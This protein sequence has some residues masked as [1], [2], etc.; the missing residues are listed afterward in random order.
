MPSVWPSYGAWQWQGAP[1]GSWAR[2]EL[3]EEAAGR[4]A[5]GQLLVKST[6][7]FFLQG[8]AVVSRFCCTAELTEIPASTLT[9]HQPIFQSNLLVQPSPPSHTYAKVF[10]IVFFL[11]PSPSFSLYELSHTAKVVMKS[12]AYGQDWC[13]RHLSSTELSASASLAFYVQHNG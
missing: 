8:S 4:D 3:H 10:K 13:F 5:T 11:L 6:C 2:Q 9:H 7:L 1:A 12:S